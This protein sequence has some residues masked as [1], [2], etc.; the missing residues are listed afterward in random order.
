MPT[1]FP[2]PQSN[3]GDSEP[4]SV[5]DL[6]AET[7]RVPGQTPQAP[8]EF[9]D[10]PIWAA[11]VSEPLTGVSIMSIEGQ[12]LWMNEQAAR[13]WHGKFA[14]ASEYSGRP[15]RELFPPEI[16]DENLAML[17]RVGTTKRAILLRRIWRGWQTL[18]WMHP[19]PGEAAEQGAASVGAIPPRIL[20]ISRR[21]GG[22]AL[23]DET[24][25]SKVE[26]VEADIADLGPLDALSERELE[27][28]ALLGQGLSVKEIAALLFR[29]A[30]TIENHRQ[31]IGRKLKL[32]DR[33][34]L[35][36]VA[37]RAGLTVRDAERT[38]S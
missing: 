14:Q 20:M 13:I 2:S 4:K 22:D 5:L 18:V 34:K 30:K 32:D 17:K 37:R 36:E 9:K 19:I 10:S 28:L 25:S 15:M 27:V 31:S 3:P 8:A 35:A 6:A 7:V 24:L 23:S 16:V 1:S 29:S 11:L 38:R 21:V 33:V 26:V 12:V